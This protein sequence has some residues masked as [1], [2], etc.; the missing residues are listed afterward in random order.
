MAASAG[1]QSVRDVG[2][3]AVPAGGV[4]GQRVGEAESG[5]LV[6]EVA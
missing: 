1:R 6:G 3:V 2:R 4:G 5:V